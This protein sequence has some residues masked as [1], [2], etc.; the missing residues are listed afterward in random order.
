LAI[1]NLGKKLL[2]KPDEAVVVFQTELVIVEHCRKGYEN[3]SLWG[4]VHKSLLLTGKVYELS[5]V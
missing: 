1:P 2:D 5:V 4:F 3:A